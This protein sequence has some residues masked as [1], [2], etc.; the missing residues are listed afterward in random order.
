M[1]GIS[2]TSDLDSELPRKPSNLPTSIRNAPSPATSPSEE[3]SLRVSASQPKCKEPSSSEEITFTTSLNTIDT[4]KDT[5]TSQ[6][7]AHQPSPSRKVIL[8]S[9]VNA[10]LSA[11]PSVSTS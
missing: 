7:T 4:K 6:S 3:E 9:L 5:E 10:D 11:R 1:S 8:S 2:R